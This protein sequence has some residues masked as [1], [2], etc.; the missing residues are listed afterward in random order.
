MTPFDYDPAFADP[1]ATPSGWNVTPGTS[2]RVWGCERPELLISETLAFHDRRTED[3]PSEQ[4]DPAEGDGQTDPE[5]VKPAVNPDPNKKYDASFDQR[6]KPEG[7]LFVEL[8]NPWSAMEPRSGDLY[9]APN[10]GVELTKVSGGSPVWR[11]IIVDRADAAKDPDDPDPTKLP[12]IER[13]IYFAGPTAAPTLPPGGTVKLQPDDTHAGR[14]APVLPGRYALIGP[15]KAGDSGKSVTYLGFRTGENPGNVAANANQTRRIE[16]NPDKVP[17]Q[18]G[19]VKVFNDG[20][21]DDLDRVTPIKNPTAVVITLPATDRLSISEPDGGYKD[22]GPSGA[23]YD[24][25]TVGYNPAWDIPLDKKSTQL[26]DVKA[27][28]QN[29]GRTDNLK[30]IHLQRLANPLLPYNNTPSSPNYN[31]Y[32]TVDS[33]PVDLTAFNGIDPG[34]DPDVTNHTNEHQFYARQ[35]GQNNSPAGTNNLWTQEPFNKTP[36]ANTNLTAKGIPTDI[37]GEPFNLKLWPLS[38]SL[39]FLNDPYGVPNATAGYE[40]D[41]Q[42]PFPWL[43][44]DN[45]PYVNPLEMMQ[46]P[47]HAVVAIAALVQHEPRERS[48]HRGRQHGLVP[49]PDQLLPLRHDHRRRGIAPRVRVSGSAVAVRGDGDAGQS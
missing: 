44:W 27:A 30:V 43:T 38:H 9:T 41:P 22:V 10:G 33:M 40:G 20:T 13:A 24:E 31:P 11:M 36:A 21:T 45:R 7:S 15:G 5:T 26:A 12:T 25:L 16:L 42:Q 19:Q 3:T 18:A 39:G 46:V 17:D 28:I 2:P 32:R 14:I 8:Y 34:N 29:N 1:A 48:V 4:V 23:N 35:R 47:W 6:Y 37:S 49:A